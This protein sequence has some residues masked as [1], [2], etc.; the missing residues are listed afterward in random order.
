MNPVESFWTE[1]A[2][3]IAALLLSVVS[4]HFSWKQ[5]RLAH[6]QDLRRK[7]L[8]VAQYLEG[9]LKTD[10][11]AR[12]RSY[13]FK[14]SVSN[15][16]DTDNA[17]ARIEL[18]VHYCLANGNK[19]VARVAAAE[20]IHA[21]LAVPQRIGAHETLAGWCGFE[22]NAGLSPGHHIDAYIIEVTDSHGEIAV[23]APILLSERGDAEPV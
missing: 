2:I 21:D 15:P 12:S 1:Q 18:A 11:D 22:S 6:V 5:H 17:L 3:A 14:L 13:R 20:A 23:V 7:P 4:L 9:H 10:R 19:M 8:L 16:S